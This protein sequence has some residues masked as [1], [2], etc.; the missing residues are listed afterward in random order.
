[1]AAILLP[2]KPPV[3]ILVRASARARRLSLRV[4]ALDGRVTMT[5]PRG[6]SRRT[7]ETFAAEKNDWIRKHLAR[8]PQRD[9]RRADR[10]C[11]PARL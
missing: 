8:Q 5:I 11:V 6:V 2:G 7:A 10:A 1:M 4:S 9:H 3:E